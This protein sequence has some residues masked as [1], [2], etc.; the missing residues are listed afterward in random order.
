VPRAGAVA[1]AP[2]AAAPLN[3]YPYSIKN[4]PR[5]RSLAELANE[6]INGGRTRDKLA[7]DVSAAELPECANSGAATGLFAIIAV[8]INMAR[9]K[10]K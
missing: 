8:P 10:C 6:Q 5:Q 1:P 7:D 2:A 9:G 4:A 3:L